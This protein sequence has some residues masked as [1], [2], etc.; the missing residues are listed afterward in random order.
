MKFVFNIDEFTVFRFLW[1]VL[2][3]KDVYL[4]KIR[5]AISPLA[6]T[7]SSLTDWIVEKN[8]ASRL[9]DA[10]PELSLHWE[11]DRRYFFKEIFAKYEPW[12][13]V[14]YKF[15]EIDPEDTL[16]GYG[17]KQITCNH[18]FPLVQDIHFIDLALKKFDTGGI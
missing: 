12:Q 14:Y 13:D 4:L 15:E 8:K 17:Y 3:R 5:P 10:L 9:V 7:L 1:Y 11:Y 6:G 2:L 16:Y 18:T